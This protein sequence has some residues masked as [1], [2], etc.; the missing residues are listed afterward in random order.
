MKIHK[1]KIIIETP[2]AN[3]EYEEEFE[4]V[5]WTGCDKKEILE[6][7]EGVANQIREENF[8]YQLIEL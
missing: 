7:A 6:E 1:F 5:E 8:T 4:I 3:V 2:F